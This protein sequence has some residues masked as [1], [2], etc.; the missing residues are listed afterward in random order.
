MLERTEPEPFQLKGNTLTGSSP[1]K[2][3][4]RTQ[5]LSWKKTS[6]KSLKEVPITEGS[7]PKY[8]T[9]K[10]KATKKNSWVDKDLTKSPEKKCFDKNRAVWNANN[11]NNKKEPLRP[12]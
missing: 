10:D 6:A 5:S 3:L 9:K 11:N 1:T 12:E 2:V 7:H 8:Y 4:K